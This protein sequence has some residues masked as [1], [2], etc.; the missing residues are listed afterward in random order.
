MKKLLLMCLM[1]AVCFAQ[2]T[3][4]FDTNK[5]LCD[6]ENNA[7]ACTLTGSLYAIGD[8]PDYDKAIEY[9]TKGC[10]GKDSGGCLSAGGAYLM[11]IGVKKDEAKA[12]QFY[13]KGCDLGDK[14]SCEIHKS[15]GKALYDMLNN[16][17]NKYSDNKSNK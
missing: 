15:N 14:F 11:G 9:T 1:S 3:L 8:K 5:E 13:K 2:L 6:K 4:D 7:K 10:N 12:M 16:F 17:K